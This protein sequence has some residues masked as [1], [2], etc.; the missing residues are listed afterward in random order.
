VKLSGPLAGVEVLVQYASPADGE[1][2]RRKMRSLGIFRETEVADGRAQDYL[3]EFCKAYV[4]DW[5]G[6]VSRGGEPVQYEPE[7]LARVMGAIGSALQ[8]ITEAVGRQD[9][10]FAS[11]G[12]VST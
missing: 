10:F 8:E 12:S 3:V 6:D 5:R 1:K 7:S 9:A 2:F 4:K 11:G